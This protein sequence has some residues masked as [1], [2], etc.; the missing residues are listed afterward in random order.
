MSPDFPNN[1]M[2]AQNVS[3]LLLNVFI[4]DLVGLLRWRSQKRQIPS[5]LT[6]LLKIDGEEIVKVSEFIIDCAK[7]VFAIPKNRTN[8]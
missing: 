1:L 3:L 7:E 5:V 6:S 8:L 2:Y 4:V